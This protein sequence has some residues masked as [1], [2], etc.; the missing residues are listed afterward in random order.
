MILDDIFNKTKEDLKLKKKEKPY[1]HLESMMPKNRAFKDVKS[2]LKRNNEKLN[3]IAEL[4]KASPS[5]GVI[6]EN[7]NFLDLAQEYE[8]AGVAAISVLTEEHFFKGSLSYLNELSKK[9]SLPL[10]RKD[11]IFDEYQILESFNAGA[12]FLLLIAK[13]LS[14]EELKSLY[15]FAKSLNLEVLFEIHSEEDLEKAIFAEAKIIGVNHR[16]LDDFSMDMKLGYKLFE[17]MPKELIRVAESGLDDKNILLELDS[18]G[19]DAF[20]IGEYF[21]RQSDV[22]K[23]SLD[24]VRR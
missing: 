2:L 3:I 5:K 17:L 16:N 23:A 8:R 14:K 15:A 22:F 24:F 4:K 12:D 9:L 21:M 10:L 7:F 18:A 20:L 13:S 6:R 1:K 11:F 19:V